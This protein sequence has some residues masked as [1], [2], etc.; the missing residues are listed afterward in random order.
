MCQEVLEIVCKLNKKN[1]NLQLALQCAP[2]I[3]GVKI[4]NLFP[5]KRQQEEVFRML[6]RKSHLHYFRLSDGGETD[7]VTYL[8]YRRDELLAYLQKAQVRAFLQSCG[9]N[10]YSLGAVLRRFQQRYE[11]YMR[12]E[13][14]EFPH[15]M[16]MILGYPVEDVVGFIRNDGQNYLYR[17]YWKVYDNVTEKKK[18]FAQYEAAKEELV[19]LIAANQ[20]IR[21]II[22]KYQNSQV[23]SAAC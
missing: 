6:F 12:G 14:N 22:Q 7:R 4:S 3:T 9:Y 15:E 20:D 18:I 16:G 1:F 23:D 10:S 5:M 21:T 2:T 19:R 13:S 8:L 17:G 11:N